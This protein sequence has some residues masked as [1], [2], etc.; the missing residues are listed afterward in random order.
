MTS[1][2]AKTIERIINERLEDWSDFLIPSIVEVAWTM[3]S[4]YISK[5]DLMK[6]KMCFIAE[7]KKKL[8]EL[9]R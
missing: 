8:K 4:R 7:S 5:E 9:R 2:E 6:I 3:S 1:E